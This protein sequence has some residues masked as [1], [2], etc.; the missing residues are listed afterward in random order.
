MASSTLFLSEELIK[1][2]GFTTFGWVSVN[3][4]TAQYTTKGTEANDGNLN[5]TVTAEGDGS[6]VDV[7]DSSYAFR[8][9]PIPESI[10]SNQ[11]SLLSVLSMEGF[12]L[13]KFVPS[14]PK[15]DGSGDAPSGLV[16]VKP[17]ASSVKPAFEIFCGA[18]EIT[19]V[20]SNFHEIDEL[21]F[22]M[23]RFIKTFKK[24]FQGRPISLNNRFKVRFYTQFIHFHIS[25]IQGCADKRSSD[26]ET[27]GMERLSIQNCDNKFYQVGAST[28]ISVTTLDKINLENISGV[29]EYRISLQ[30]VGGLSNVTN[31]ICSTVKFILSTSLDGKLQ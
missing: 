17:L 9:W 26:E 12:S 27:L 14:N 13:N 22:D 19:L 8:I 18:E 2:C 11:C 31:E 7:P 20:I 29:P 6:E 24:L 15:L 3:P 23:N 25:K 10:G 21:S 30:D 16:S 4:L 5:V 1:E 28:V